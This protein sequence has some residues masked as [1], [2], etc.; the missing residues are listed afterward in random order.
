MEQSLAMQKAADYLDSIPRFASDKHE[1]RDVRRML[2]ALCAPRE[3]KVIHV[4]GT[5]GKGSVCAF[6]TA[7]FRKRGEHTATFI[8]PHLVS[9]RERF[10]FD[11]EPVPEEDF[12]SAYGEVREKAEEFARE[13]LGYPTFFEFLFLMFM[14]MP[15]TASADRVILETGL[16][17]RLD[18]TNCLE[19][20][21]MA[22]ITS[23]GLD[24]MQY[25]GD[26]VELIAAE[27]AGILKHSVPAVYDGTDRGA[28]EVIRRR[29]E[30][31]GAPAEGIFPESALSHVMVGDGTISYRIEPEG[32]PVRVPFAAPYQAM[33]SLLAIRAANRLGV[34]LKEAAEGVSQASWAGRMELSGKYRNIYLDGAHNEHGVRAFAEAAAGAA[35]HWRE[36]KTGGRV[37][38]LFGAA[39]DKQFGEM[40]RIIFRAVR[41]D[42]VILTQARGTRA[43]DAEVLKKIA[44]EAAGELSLE[45]EIRVLRPVK[46]AYEALRAECGEEDLAF[47]A[48][49]LYLIGE[50]KEVM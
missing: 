25:L 50:L 31:I 24:H 37:F 1:I 10:L 27:K 48:G 5:N 46:E 41:P 44:G 16:G 30:E 17:G 2:L 6:L 42:S 4:A 15:G 39:Q 22:V 40:I 13:G 29:A 32:I 36:K 28:A 35:A 8:S 14:V 11:G 45:P 18:A 3:E 12:L 33:N 43:E 19:K 34:P 47:C 21:A 26:T 20:P 7:I 38:L 49:S 23:I 9:V